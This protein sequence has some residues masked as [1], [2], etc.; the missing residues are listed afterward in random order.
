MLAKDPNPNP[1]RIWALAISF[2]DETA[3]QSA[4]L[5]ILCVNDDELSALTE[6]AL[7]EF[8]F[9]TAKEHALLLRWGVDAVKEARVISLSNRSVRCGVH[10]SRTRRLSDISGSTNPLILWDYPNELAL[11]WLIRAAGAS[12]VQHGCSCASVFDCSETAVHML[13]RLRAVVDLAKR[14]CSYIPTQIY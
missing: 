9:V 1:L 3:R 5:R 8:R 2:E 13:D 14:Q 6:Q 7:E 12:F 4:M 11:A 10:G